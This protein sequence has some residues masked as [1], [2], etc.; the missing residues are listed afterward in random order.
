MARVWN[1]ATVLGMPGKYV[2]F[3]KS[4]FCNIF[5]IATAMRLH[6]ILYDTGFHT[7]IVRIQNSDDVYYSRQKDK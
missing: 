2:V 4:P 1:A 7:R 5:I 3:L 6:K